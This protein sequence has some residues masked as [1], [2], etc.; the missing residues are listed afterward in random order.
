MKLRRTLILREK[1]RPGSRREISSSRLGGKAEDSA[2]TEVKGIE[3]SKMG[4]VNSTKFWK[5]VK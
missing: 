5:E 1:R 3:I 4:E 2:I